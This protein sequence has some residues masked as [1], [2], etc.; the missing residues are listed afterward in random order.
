MFSYV[1]NLSNY[2]NI[3]ITELA[4]ELIIVSNFFLRFLFLAL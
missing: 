4:F 2:K 3:R 1:Y